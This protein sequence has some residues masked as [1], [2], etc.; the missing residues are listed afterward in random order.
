MKRDH[1][2]K[3][4][5]TAI[6]SAMSA[7]LMFLSFS[8]PFAPPYLKIEFSDLPA[9]LTSFSLGPLWGVAVSFIKVLINIQSDTFYAGELSNF[10]LSAVFVFVS[11]CIYKANKTKKSA[12]IGMSVGTL[13]TAFISLFTNY[14][15]IY[16]FYFGSMG[17][18]AVVSMAS[19]ILPFVDTKTEIILIFNFPF[20]I[21]KCALNMLLAL[22]L[23]KRISPVIKSG[24]ITR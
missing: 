9:L 3:I 13:T 4:T 18:D 24:K 8:V 16:P 10:I 23:Y 21:L 6:F 22:F 5:V 12:V 2:R 1:I 20:T 17:F 11:G 19:S 15:I 14:F 7:L